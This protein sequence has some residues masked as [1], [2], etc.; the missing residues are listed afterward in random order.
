LA[1]TIYG[2]M[3][4]HVTVINQAGAFNAEASLA[5]AGLALVIG[6]SMAHP[7]PRGLVAAVAFVLVVLPLTVSAVAEPTDVRYSG[8]QTLPAIV[9]AQWQ[10]GEHQKVLQ[11]S[12]ERLVNAELVTPESLTLDGQSLGYR[13]SAAMRQDSASAKSL[14]NIA[15]NLVAGSPTDLTKPLADLGIGFVFA[16]KPTGKLVAALDSSSMLEAVGTTEL[17]RLWRVP[18]ANA[19]KIDAEPTT[20]QLWSITKAIQF[21]A[22]LVFVLM[23]LPTASRRRKARDTSLDE[24]ENVDVA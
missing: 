11:L 20:G 12:G 1:A 21:L 19:T 18:S 16:P 9:N 14:T 13:L 3:L 15:A 22:I 7:R 6:I 8:N 4:S 24:S 10:Q 17:G 23:A 2:W 5:L